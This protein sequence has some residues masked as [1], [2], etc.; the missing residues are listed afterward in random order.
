M[1]WK[2]TISK[3]IGSSEVA[4]GHNKVSEVEVTAVSE[5]KP[6]SLGRETED[7]P[8]PLPESIALKSCAFRLGID[9]QKLPLGKG[10]RRYGGLNEKAS[11]RFIYL[12]TWSS[13]GR[14]V[15][16]GLLG[17][18]LLEEVSVGAGF[19]QFP[20]F[21]LCLLVVVQDV[22]L[23]LSLYSAIMVSLNSLKP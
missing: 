23:L 4:L 5:A 10:L 17:V 9:L 3:L 8:F 2:T 16:E 15:W 21:L 19:V 1:F 6:W 12:K 22:N 11:H 13:G 14:T 20:V 7:L 18:T